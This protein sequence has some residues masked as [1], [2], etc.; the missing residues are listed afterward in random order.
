MCKTSSSYADKHTPWHSKER[1][2]PSP[3]F[4]STWHFGKYPIPEAVTWRSLQWGVGKINVVSVLG[5]LTKSRFPFLPAV[6][7]KPMACSQLA[8]HLHAGKKKSLCCNTCISSGS[9]TFNQKWRSCNQPYLVLP[10]SCLWEATFFLINGKLIWWI[11]L[12][13]DWPT[14]NDTIL[15]FNYCVLIWFFL[16]L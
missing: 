10:K 13:C 14:T 6:Q 9:L 7:N 2:A 15:F 16:P 4:H 5:P 3:N 1:V 12:P 8:T 11:I